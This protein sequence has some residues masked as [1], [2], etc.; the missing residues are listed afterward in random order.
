MKETLLCVILFFCFVYGRNDS[1]SRQTD[2]MVV[3]A[4]RATGSSKVN[5][6]A[7]EKVIGIQDDLNQLL[8]QKPGVS[9][10]PEAGSLLIVNGDGPFDNQYYIRGIPVFPPSDFVGQ[11]FA[12][13]SVV[14]LALP[15]DIHF[16]TYDLVS[17]Y[18]G[19]S[20]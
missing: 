16:Y 5:Q 9:S 1:L 6:K 8:L 19:V 13:R 18:S 10:V 3:R 4:P 17:K 14:S 11:T 15:S 7:I 2:T 12:D 20:G